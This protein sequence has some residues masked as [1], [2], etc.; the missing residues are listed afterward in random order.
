MDLCLYFPLLLCC[1]AWSNIPNYVQRPCN[2]PEVFVFFGPSKKTHRQ[3]AEVCHAGG[4]EKNHYMHYVL[5]EIIKQHVTNT[6]L[7]Y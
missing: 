2:L 7:E 5:G 3:H 6:K 1:G 4:T